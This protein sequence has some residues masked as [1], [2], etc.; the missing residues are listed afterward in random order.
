MPDSA[1]SPQD[2]R[3]TERSALDAL[4]GLVGPAVAEALWDIAVRELVLTRPVDSAGDLVRVA[5]HLMETGDLARVAGRSL[6]I[7]TVTYAAL[8]A[9]SPQ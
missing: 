3:P 1:G 4:G 8:N 9:R 6:K 5:E 2:G 7:R